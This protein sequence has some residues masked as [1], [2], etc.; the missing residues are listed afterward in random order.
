MNEYGY[1][2]CCSKRVTK[3]KPIAINE[4]IETVNFK[5]VFFA[6]LPIVVVE[7]FFVF[8]TDL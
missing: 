3:N 2:K 7:G 6:F 4:N 1:L 8:S 5:F